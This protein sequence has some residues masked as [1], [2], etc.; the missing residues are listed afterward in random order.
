MN[1]EDYE[2]NM[3]ACFW[4]L[5]GMT[6]MVL[7]ALFTSCSKK[8]Y[9][10]LETVRTDTLYVAKR[11]SVHIVDSLVTHHVVSV[12]DSVAVHDSTVVI[13]D[14]H[15]NVKERLVVRYRDRWHTS[16]DNLSL[17]REISRYKAENDSLRASKSQ[18]EEVPVPV[19][20]KLTAWERIKVRAG[21][22]AMSLCIVLSAVI[23]WMVKRRRRQ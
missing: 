18:R 9:V 2:N 20:R 19:E 8:V 14:E 4:A 23:A 12:R 17:Q 1:M 5:V 22:W 6:L 16:A 15:G 11:D 10:P 7:L 3:K 13:M 21:G